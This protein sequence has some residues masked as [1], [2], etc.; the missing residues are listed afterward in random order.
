MAKYV[1]KKPEYNFLIQFRLIT[2]SYILHQYSVDMK[3][4]KIYHSHTCY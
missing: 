1:M 2:F 4:P 3:P